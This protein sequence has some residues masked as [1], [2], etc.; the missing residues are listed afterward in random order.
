M[1]GEALLPQEQILI[2]VSRDQRAGWRYASDTS[3]VTAPARKEIKVALSTQ[4]QADLSNFLH[5]TGHLAQHGRT[6][7]L[8]GAIAN[9]SAGAS[10]PVL[11]ALA[12]AVLELN[13]SIKK[14]ERESK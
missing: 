12:K 2:T 14:L 7:R 4:T 5:G 10:E 3:L 1:S 8:A 6:S 9:V 13:E 11:R